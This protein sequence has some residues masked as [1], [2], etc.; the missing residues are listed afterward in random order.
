MS[1]FSAW[2][3]RWVHLL[4]TS[5]PIED[6]GDRRKL[7]VVG[8][9]TVVIIGAV[10]L[11]W[12][13]TRDD[14]DP[15]PAVAT[16]PTGPIGAPVEQELTGAE[17][18]KQTPQLRNRAARFAAAYFMATSDRGAPARWLNQMAD[19]A[20]PSVHR[21][22]NYAARSA[23]LRDYL[24]TRDVRAQVAVTGPVVHDDGYGDDGLWV[25]V[26]L[27]IRTSVSGRRQAPLRTRLIVRV[28][29]TAPNQW[30]IAQ[31]GQ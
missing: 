5:G 7:A 15:V 12:M 16:S 17:L 25:R 31:V 28:E 1:R 4:T 22:V 20:S 3:R 11:T 19:L 14:A 26:P 2:V 21:D 23:Q 10:G 9:T 24:T 13:N 8:I 30:R 27:T 18:V 6:E 29:E